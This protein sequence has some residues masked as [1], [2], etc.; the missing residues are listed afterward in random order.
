MAEGWP[1]REKG[2]P[3]TAPEFSEILKLPGHSSYCMSEN[4]EPPVAFGQ[5]WV[6]SA[7]TVNLVRV[8]VDPNRR[9]RGFGKQLSAFL[10][11]EA[12]KLPQASTVRL[13]V[14]RANI[15]A[16]SLYTSLGFFVVETESN[17]SVLALAAG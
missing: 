15:A 2:I 8:I 3:I 11:A 6:S 16:V 7:N 9:G 13:R 4:G 5:I 1:G 14:L 12:R 17:E 10:L